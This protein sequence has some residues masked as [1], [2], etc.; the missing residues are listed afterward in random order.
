M[1][2]EY[3]SKELAEPV[4]LIWLSTLI[5]LNPESGV[6]ALE[7]KLRDIEPEPLSKAVVWFTKLFNERHDGINI[8]NNDFTPV[9]LLRLVRLAYLHI[10]RQDDAEHEGSYTPDMRDNAEYARNAILTALLESQGEEGWQVK[11]D[12][13]IDPLFSHFKDRVLA[14]AQEAWAK[15]IDS[16]LLD[17]QL[18]R[19]GRHG[20]ESIRSGS[21][22]V[23]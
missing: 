2:K 3:I 7:E 22:G 18:F 9:L 23:K 16:A 10:R 11:H 12:M 19:Q 8:R 13:A 1:A 21:C 20:Q 15:E 5:R 17:E 14:L 4:I 6:D